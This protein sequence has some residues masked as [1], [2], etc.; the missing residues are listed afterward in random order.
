M[1]DELKEKAISL[2]KKGSTYSE[3]LKEIP[4]AKSTLSVWLRD[5]GLVKQQEQKLT[6]KR[7]EAS[8]RGGEARRRQRIEST[9]Q[10]MSIGR[11]EVGK[12]SKRELLLIGAALYWAEGSKERENNTGIGVE[13]INSD[14]QMIYLFV[15]WLIDVCNV[16]KN[17]FSFYIYIHENSRFREKKVINHW[18]R[19]TG[20]GKK[21]FDYVYYKKH[22]IQT[23][24]KKVGDDYFGCLKIR[25]KASS[26]LQRRIMGWVAGINENCPIV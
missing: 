17:D 22:N 13:F 11:S 15:K 10:I 4:V 21:R 2:R 3:I 16:K 20:F 18:S 1:K 25:I 19:C 9:R 24:R 6:K 14:S 8:R 7:R 26:H 12:I 23:K 5:V